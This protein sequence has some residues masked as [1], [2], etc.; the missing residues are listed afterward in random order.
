MKLCIRNPFI[1]DRDGIQAPHLSNIDSLPSQLPRGLL[2]LLPHELLA[3]DKQTD[4]VTGVTYVLITVVTVEV[5][6]G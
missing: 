3:P 5:Q 1:I 2:V 6:K 4:K